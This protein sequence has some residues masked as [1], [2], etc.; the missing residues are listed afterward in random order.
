MKIYCVD[1]ET[2]GVTDFSKIDIL[3]CS[4]V[5]VETKTVLMNDFIKPEINT[6]WE[7]AEKV[8]HISPDM[9]KDG[10][11]IEDAALK[12]RK[13]LGEADI[14]VSYNG[15]QFDLPLIEYKFNIKFDALKYDVMLEFRRNFTLY[16]KIP[17]KLE[18][19][20][21]ALDIVNVKAHDALGDVNATIAL[22]ERMQKEMRKPRLSEAFKVGEKLIYSEM[23]AEQYAKKVGLP[24]S[25]K[26]YIVNK[27]VVPV[28]SIKNL[29]KYWT[30][31]DFVKPSSKN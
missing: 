5:D 20:C 23:L 24:I 10:L 27:K 18:D 9:V 7:E 21:K 19:A 29:D 14:I 26:F 1:L 4:I 25:Q 2:T 15:N 3:Q 17:F 28:D 12:I 30:L 13:F 16:E 8:N 22:Y 6:S 31:H 11:S